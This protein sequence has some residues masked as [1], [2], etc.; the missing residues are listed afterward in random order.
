MG[1]DGGPDLGPVVRD[2]GPT[3]AEPCEDPEIC[4]AAGDD[5]MCVN[6]FTDSE[7]CG[8][9]GRDCVGEGR[10]ERCRASSCVCGNVPIGCLGTRQS[11]CCPPRGAGGTAYCANFDRDIR[12]CDG[13][14]Q[15]CPDGIT[16][17]C[18]GGVCIC[19]GEGAP[20]E[21]GLRCCSSVGTSACVDVDTD[22]DHCG[23][24][25]VVCRFNEAC[26]GGQCTRGEPCEERCGSGLICCDGSCCLRAS[27]G[28]EGCS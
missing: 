23:A 19:G 14:D 5:A 24:C 16:D 13:C 21:A 15:A 7:N 28:A 11:F 25:G 3:C 17:Q 4:C 18:A 26:V 12:D 6:T 27:C 8:V 10:G 20:C 22:P 1:Q 2:E 9:C